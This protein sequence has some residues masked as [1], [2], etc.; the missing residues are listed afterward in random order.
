MAG[1]SRIKGITVYLCEKEQTGTDGLNRPIYQETETPVDNVLVG[2]PSTDDV[3]SSVNLYGKKVVY[4]LCI[5]KGDTHDWADTRVR[6]RGAMY[7]TIGFPVEW[8]EENVPGSW[9]KKVMVE[10]HG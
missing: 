7:R 8:I 5:P 6:I 1:F 3:T 4:T 9:N 10:R 2:E